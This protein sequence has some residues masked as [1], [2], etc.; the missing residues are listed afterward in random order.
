MNEFRLISTEL[1]N[2]MNV[3]LEQEMKLIRED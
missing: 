2:Q 3:E 1:V